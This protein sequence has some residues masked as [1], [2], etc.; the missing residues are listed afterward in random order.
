MKIRRIVAG[1]LFGGALL[2]A[3]LAGC[4]VAAIRYEYLRTYETAGRS[5]ITLEMIGREQKDK[6]ERVE[7]AELICALSRIDC[8]PQWVGRFNPSDPNLPFPESRMIERRKLVFLAAAQ[9]D[10]LM[11]FSGLTTNDLERILNTHFGHEERIKAE[12]DPRFMDELR[13]GLRGSE[14]KQTVG[15]RDGQ[16]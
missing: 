1:V 7:R 4:F 2:A 12:L 14:T 13:K 10:L 9:A 8:F 5:L 15:A 11:R 6:L 16:R 3:F